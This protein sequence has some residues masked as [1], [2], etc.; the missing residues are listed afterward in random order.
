MAMFLV[1]GVSGAGKTTLVK[2]LQDEHIF[3]ECI[4]HTTREMREG[5]EDGLQYYFVDKDEFKKMLSNGEFAEFV[6]YDGN[7]YAV[8]KAEIEGVMKSGYD[9]CIIV[10][11]NGYRQLKEIYPDA[12]GIFLY[13][14][15]EDCLANML[16][17]GD[18]IEKAMARIDKYDDEMKNKDEY[19]YVIK[20]IRGKYQ[21]MANIISSICKQYSSW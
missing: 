10:D 19:D 11:N 4:S 3:K 18:S 13:M 16:L 6:T 20:N 1:T 15:K 9:V 12:I 17:R 5:E 14:S 21:H 2:N 8:S 7:S